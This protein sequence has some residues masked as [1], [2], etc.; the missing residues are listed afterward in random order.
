MCP[1]EVAF[2][3]A[4]G[5]EEAERELRR[6][7]TEVTYFRGL[8]RR[9]MALPANTVAFQAFTLFVIGGWLDILT[10]LQLSVFA[11]YF[12]PIFM[13]SFLVSPRAGVLMALLAAMFRGSA[14]YLYPGHDADLVVTGWNFAV[15]LVSFLIFTFLL[16]S[17]REQLDNE[18][19]LARYD[20]LTLVLNRLAFAEVCTREFG[21]QRRMG[22]EFTLAY[23]DLDNFKSVNDRHGHETGDFCLKTVANVLARQMRTADTVARLGGDEFALLFPQT[24]ATNAGL[25]LARV[26]TA[27]AEAMTHEG[28]PVTFSMGA[29]TF[30]NVPQ[31]Y[32][33]AIAAADVLLYR[34]KA[35]GKN[36]LVQ[37]SISG[38]MSKD[39]APVSDNS[40]ANSPEPEMSR[41]VEAAVDSAP[42]NPEA[43]G[44]GGPGTAATVARAVPHVP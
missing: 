6:R 39:S 15:D 20:S 25:V 2:T 9:I 7:R 18:N 44:S 27:L 19:A 1:Q 5:R 28:W 3:P 17:V 40:E 4:P 16:A 41:K 23:L 35:Q 37:E 8:L 36:Q 11:F 12:V 30:I 34:A 43:T 14:A 42:A 38:A 13:A 24:D 33:E 21:R 32:D 29:A 26:Q 10:G 22:G 31:T